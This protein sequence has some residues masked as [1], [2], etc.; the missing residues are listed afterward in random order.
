M[1]ERSF[2][3]GSVQNVEKFPLTGGKIKLTTATFW[4]PSGRNLNKASTTGKEEEDWGVRP[5]KGYALK[6]DRAEKDEL[7]DRLYNWRV[8]PRKRPAAQGDEEGLQGPAARHGPGVPAGPDQGDPRGRQGRLIAGVGLKSSGRRGTR[9]G[10]FFGPHGP[11]PWPPHGPSEPRT[12]RNG[13]QRSGAEKAAKAGTSGDHQCARGAE[14][15]PLTP[16]HSAVPCSAPC[17][18]PSQALCSV[19]CAAL[20]VRPITPHCLWNLPS[21]APRLITDNPNFRYPRM[22]LRTPFAALAV[23]GLLAVGAVPADKPEASKDALKALNEFVGQWKGNG[24]TKSGKTENWKENGRVELM[25]GEEPALKVKFTGGKQFSGGT[26]K[27]L[28][29]KKK[30]QLTATTTDKKEQVY[31]GEIKAKRLVLTHEDADTKDKYSIEMSTNNDVGRGSCTTCRSK[32]RGSELRGGWCR[33][34]SLR[35][36]CR[37]P[38]ARRTSASSPAGWG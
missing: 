21:R 37:S 10:L 36:A 15:R 12:E 17:A 26:L 7:F 20:T 6:L 31:T 30:Y 38:A 2:G 32:R 29:D 16:L 24:E 14:G 9:A 11:V 35:K 34:I 4:P 3:K 22:Y 18:G 19:P 8:I 23:L 28:P 1:G 13:A 33:R 5:D 25:K 27:Y